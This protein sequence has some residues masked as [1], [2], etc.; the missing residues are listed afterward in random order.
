MAMELADMGASRLSLVSR[1]GCVADEKLQKMLDRLQ[2]SA[3]TVDAV[4]CDVADYGKTS[5]MIDRIRQVS[6]LTGIVHAAGILD[7][8]GLSFTGCRP[9]T[10]I[11]QGE[12]RWSLEPP[13]QGAGQLLRAVLLSLRFGRPAGASRFT[14][15]KPYCTDR[16][17]AMI[18]VTASH[19]EQAGWGDGAP[20]SPPPSVCRS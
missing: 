7:F 11:V 1:R 2:A 18:R 20:T 14:Q 4:S 5:E 19:R 8:C 16:P 12:G 6:E 10:V 3:S 9:F 17:Q 13:Q 15:S